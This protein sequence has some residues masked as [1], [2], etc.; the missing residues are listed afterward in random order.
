MARFAS[1]PEMNLRVA[2]ARGGGG[3]FRWSYDFLIKFVYV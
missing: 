2:K 1:Y 3:I